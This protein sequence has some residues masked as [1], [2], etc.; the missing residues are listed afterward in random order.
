MTVD[1]L[2]ATP[3]LWPQRHQH[4]PEIHEQHHLCLLDYMKYLAYNK[5]DTETEDKSL[6]STFLDAFDTAVGPRPSARLLRVR[7]QERN[8]PRRIRAHFF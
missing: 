5:R 7:K 6:A 3:M 4:V 2:P 8:Y 1:R